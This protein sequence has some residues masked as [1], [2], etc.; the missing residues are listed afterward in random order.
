MM[1]SYSA[2]GALLLASL[3]LITA[4]PVHA[5]TPGYASS[6]HVLVLNTEG[7]DRGHATAGAFPT[8]AATGAGYSVDFMAAASVTGAS[9][10]S[11]HDTI[12]LWMYCAVGSDTTV[13]NA[14]IS[15]LQTGGK[16]IIWDSDACNSEESLL[17]DYSWLST[18]GASFAVTTPGQT[19]NTG[20]SL[21]IQE[22]NNF[23]N[24][25][26]A[27]DLTNL[28]TDTDAVGD[29]NAVTSNSAAWCGI[30]YGTNTI[31][32]SGFGQAYTAPGALTGATGA[33]MLYTGL[34]TN[35]IT[36]GPYYYSGY[37]D[38]MVAM[39]LNQ[40]AHGWGNSAYTGDL[41]CSVPIPPTNVPQFGLPA[42]AM[43]AMGLIA[44]LSLR[45]FTGRKPRFP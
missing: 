39:V 42:T 4:I 45:A 40:L 27:T 34:D 35:Y 21:T 28:V 1:K 22:N 24:G 3:F 44:V 33:M 26:T 41:A 25:I 17:A 8:S 38:V 23:L 11:G 16:I 29:L 43:A 6:S 37:G 18:V 31:G 19:G 9:S 14:L 36:S 15:F 32:A 5:T 2:I 20:G 30:L 13:Q 10:F 7:N 12:V